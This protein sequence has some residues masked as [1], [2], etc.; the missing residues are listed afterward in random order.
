MLFLLLLRATLLRAPSPS[1]L[2]YLGFGVHLTEVLGLVQIPPSLDWCGRKV[3]IPALEAGQASAPTRFPLGGSCLFRSG[4]PS[5]T[6]DQDDARR[7]YPHHA[8]HV[9]D[10]A[11]GCRERHADQERRGEHGG[12][13]AKPA[14]K[15]A[16]TE[17]DNRGGRQQDG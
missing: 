16:A 4:R 3:A 7:H 6:A 5:R 8:Q 15:G 1:C 14:R 17:H 12:A 10:E 2:E 11:E 9:W 13:P